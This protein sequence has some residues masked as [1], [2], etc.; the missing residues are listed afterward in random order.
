MLMSI[1]DATY[2]NGSKSNYAPIASQTTKDAIRLHHVQSEE[3][4]KWTMVYEMI[5]EVYF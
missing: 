3:T 4:E 5:I 2:L 1:D